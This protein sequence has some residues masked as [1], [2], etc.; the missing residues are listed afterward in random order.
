MVELTQHLD[1]IIVVVGSFLGSVKA[2]VEFDRGKPLCHRV[3]D[4]VI[5]LFAGIAVTLHFGAEF[6]LWLNGLLAVVG[7]SSGA[8]ALEVVLQMLPSITRNVLKNWIYNKMK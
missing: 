4:I 2:S 6:N 1:I 5:G 8:M 3:L 7:G